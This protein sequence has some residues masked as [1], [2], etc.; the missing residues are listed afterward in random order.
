MSTAVLIG[1]AVLALGI[2]A[3]LVLVY[4]QRQQLLDLR[5]HQKTLH[6]AVKRGR[7]H[8]AKVADE[9]GRREFRQV[10]A[11]LW[12]RDLIQLP[13]PLAATR[14]WAAS[15]DL[16][17]ELAQLVQRE[18]PRLIVECGGGTST[19][20]MAAMAKRY[21]GRIVTLEHHPEFREETL[22][23]LR[24]QGLAEVVDVRLAPLVE[25]PDLHFEGEGFR[26]YDPAA[27]ADLAEIDLLFIDGPPEATG[28]LARYPALP[29]L[30]AKTS[31]RLIVV[32]DDTI[33]ADEQAISAAWTEAYLLRSQS[34][35]LEKGAHLLRR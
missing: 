27:T 15:P 13:A 18:Q 10:E 12:L 34:L 2:A 22:A 4:K 32:L 11:M 26:W 3:V 17:L 24:Q 25:I 31:Q 29:L 23:A 14:N 7:V 35:P 16:L 30:W 19:V 33:R 8:T 6:E 1:Q 9:M 28:R 21:G 20:V 5:A